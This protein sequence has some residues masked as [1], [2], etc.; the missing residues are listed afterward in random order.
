MACGT[1]RE[2]ERRRKTK[3]KELKNEETRLGAF[4]IGRCCSD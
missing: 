3:T 2:E 4:P 1:K